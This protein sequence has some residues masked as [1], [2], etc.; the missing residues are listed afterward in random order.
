[1]NYTIT[2]KTKVKNLSTGE[3]FIDYK[4]TVT[5]KDCDL[6]PHQHPM[7]N[8]DFFGGILNKA[9]KKAINNRDWCRL[10]ELPSNVSIDTTGFLAEVSIKIG[11]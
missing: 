7:Y 6:L 5:R 1:M 2:Y 4:K 9:H 8:S 3:Q 10:S 11:E